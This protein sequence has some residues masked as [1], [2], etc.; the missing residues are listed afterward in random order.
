MNQILTSCIMQ[1]P[2]FGLRRWYSISFGIVVGI[3]VFLFGAGTVSAQNR[4]QN[5]LF[6]SCDDAVA[7]QDYAVSEALDALKN[8]GDKE[9][10]GPVLI[11]ILRQSVEE[12]S[13]KLLKERLQN[14]EQYFRDRGSRLKSQ[15]VLVAVGPAVEGYGRIEYY[16]FGRLN[17]TIYFRKNGF[18]CHECC[19]PD[20]RYYPH[21][22]KAT[23]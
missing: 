22:K 11:V 19:G 16:I 14:L 12:R 8:E 10:I 3:G 20:D 7:R 13:Q 6:L 2:R 1:I 17:E 15:H 21:R 5:G 4:L 18:V 9:Q 23:R